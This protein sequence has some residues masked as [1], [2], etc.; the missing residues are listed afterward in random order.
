VRNDSELEAALL[1]CMQPSTADDMVSRQKLLD[2]FVEPFDG[3]SGV[4]LAR[5]ATRSLFAPK[6]G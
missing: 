3:Q 4:R 5:V 6:T 2:L 1:K